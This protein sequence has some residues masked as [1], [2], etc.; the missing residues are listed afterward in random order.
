MAMISIEFSCKI[1]ANESIFSVFET[2]IRAFLTFLK[3]FSNSNKLHSNL[4]KYITK[5]LEVLQCIR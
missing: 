3:E 2:L 5:Y 1:L 4:N